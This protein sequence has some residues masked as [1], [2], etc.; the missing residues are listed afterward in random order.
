MLNDVNVKLPFLKASHTNNQ[1][2]QR[3]GGFHKVKVS[4]IEKITGILEIFNNNKAF[5]GLKTPKHSH[6]MFVFSLNFYGWAE[7]R[8]CGQ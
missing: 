6:N 5:K 3:F 2:S 1:L 4:F 8:N 7:N